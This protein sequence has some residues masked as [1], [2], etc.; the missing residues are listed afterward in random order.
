[1]FAWS[2]HSSNWRQPNDSA[3]IVLLTSTQHYDV[4]NC[5]NLICQQGTTSRRSISP[6]PEV[7]SFLLDDH[8]YWLIGQTHHWWGTC[9]VGMKF[10]SWMSFFLPTARHDQETQQGVGYSHHH[11][12][13]VEN[14]RESTKSSNPTALLGS[15]KIWHFSPTSSYWVQGTR[16]S[17]SSKKHILKKLVSQIMR[18]TQE[19]LFHR[20]YLWMQLTPSIEEWSKR[21]IVNNWMECCLP[22]RDR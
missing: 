18:T 2:S 21:I 14:E 22:Q 16:T 12:D 13:S 7:W 19:N 4:H 11:R 8:K 9:R 1:M 15:N 20:I 3:E 17:N 5:T 10:N 6:I